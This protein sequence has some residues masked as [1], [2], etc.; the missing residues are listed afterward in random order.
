M[1]CGTCGGDQRRGWHLHDRAPITTALIL[2]EQ[3]AYAY[4]ATVDGEWGCCHSAEDLR[5]GGR[6]PAWEGEDFDPLPD[7][8]VGVATLKDWLP[9]IAALRTLTTSESGD[10]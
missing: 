2:A 7:Y 8:C 3:I 9:R 4:A 5:A 6:E 10:R 1:P